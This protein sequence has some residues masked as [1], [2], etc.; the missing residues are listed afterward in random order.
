MFK[1]LEGIQE[2]IYACMLV[3]SAFLMVLIILLRDIFGLSYDFLVD[4]S[5][6]LVI[7]A[8]YLAFGIVFAQKG[9]VG[10]DMLLQLLRPRGRKVLGQFNTI[11]TALF[12]GLIAYG[13]AQLVYTLFTQHQVFVRN[14]PIPMWIPK[15]CLPIGF[16]LFFL[17]ACFEFWKSVRTKG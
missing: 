5:I 12:A 8:A 13:G 10:I 17:Y 14:I 2:Q 1:K 15:L 9:H 16:L 11:V 6:W 4:A 7:W 3:A